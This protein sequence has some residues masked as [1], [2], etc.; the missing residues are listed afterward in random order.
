MTAFE[1]FYLIFKRNQSHDS[2]LVIR[3]YLQINKEILYFKNG[4]DTDNFLKNTEKRFRSNIH[5]SISNQ[6]F[7]EKEVPIIMFNIPSFVLQTYACSMNSCDTAQE[8]GYLKLDLL[9]GI[10]PH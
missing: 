9:I 4:F 6:R 3:I 5:F 8:I 1:N 2:D 7:T 10:M